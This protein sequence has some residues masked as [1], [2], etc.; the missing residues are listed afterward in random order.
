MQ[1]EFVEL[2]SKQ[3][4]SRE[5]QA[6][7]QALGQN[8]I[9]VTSFNGNFTVESEIFFDSCGVAVVKAKGLSADEALSAVAALSDRAPLASTEQN[10]KLFR[11]EGEGEAAKCQIVSQLKMAVE[12]Q[13][14]SKPL[15]GTVESVMRRNSGLNCQLELENF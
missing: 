14:V 12:V 1:A 4:S 15:L 9:T 7:P 13:G 6:F 5:G 8:S 11:Q 2:A 10:L 3:L